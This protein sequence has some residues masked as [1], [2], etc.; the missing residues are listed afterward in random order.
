MKK[1]TRKRD[2]ITIVIFG[3]LAGVTVLGVII[4]LFVSFFGPIPEKKRREM[5]DYYNDDS[6]YEVDCGTIEI[7]SRNDMHVKHLTIFDSGKS[8]LPYWVLESSYKILED[9]GFISLCNIKEQTEDQTI[10][11]FTETVTMITNHR[12]YI[13]G[14]YRRVIV[15]LSVGDTIYLDFESGKANMIEYVKSIR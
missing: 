15:G 4:Y 9:S 12:D 3:A 8:S 5:L 1:D 7:I 11:E 6:T 13:H 10:Y 14:Y 2:I